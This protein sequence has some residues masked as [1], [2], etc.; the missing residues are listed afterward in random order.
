MK[1]SDFLLQMSGQT[2]ASEIADW[3]SDSP[4]N[5]KTGLNLVIF[6]KIFA[7]A[8]PSLLLDGTTAK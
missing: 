1:K 5:S 6:Q 8:R 3:A 2:I 7:Y 4:S